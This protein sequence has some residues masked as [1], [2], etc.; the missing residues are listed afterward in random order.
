MAYIPTQPDPEL[1]GTDTEP[2]IP[3]MMT[4]DPAPNPTL[5]IFL[6]VPYVSGLE[7]PCYK[8]GIRIQMLR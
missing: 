1:F 2:R 7:R 4:S 8:T 3:K 5:D 6:S